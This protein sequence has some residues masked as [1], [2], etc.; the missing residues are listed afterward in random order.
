V[1]MIVVSPW[2]KGGWVNSQVFDHTSVIRLLEARYGVAEPN[3]TPWRRAVTGDLTSVFDFEASNR[4]PDAFLPDAS[5]L[6]ARAQARA[7]LPPPQPPMTP[8]PPPRQEPGFRPARAL[9]YALDA[10]ARIGPGG[11]DLTIANF[12][13]AGAGF[14]LYPAEAEDGGPWFYAVEAGKTLNDQLPG[15]RAGYDLTLHGPNGFLRRFR[16]GPA[17]VVEVS[18]R[19]D[20]A[21][22]QVILRNVGSGPVAVRTA[23]AYGTGKGRAHRLEPGVEV[24]DRWRIAESSHWYDIS[25]VM[26]DDLRFLR[27]LAGHVETGRPSRSDPAL[28]W[29][30]S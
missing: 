6:P 24:V 15:S 22:L 14:A 29:L 17:D 9:P 5:V 23:N 13:A 1:P 18:H 7:N 11:L 26:P 8:A 2:T 19:F 3:I 27:R 16:G 4:A 25:V 10:W 12:G 30:E 28:Q 20:G 21:A